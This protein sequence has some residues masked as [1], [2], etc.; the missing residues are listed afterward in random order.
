MLQSMTGFAALKGTAH[1]FSWGWDLRSVNSKGLDLRLRVP[2]WIDGPMGDV[3]KQVTTIQ[4]DHF[5]ELLPSARGFWRKVFEFQ[6]QNE[7][8]FELSKDINSV[9]VTGATGFLGEHVVRRLGKTLTS[10]AAASL[11]SEIVLGLA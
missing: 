6:L 1:G 9:L 4:S 8:K 7:P 10:F 11:A 2:D 5:C 3:P